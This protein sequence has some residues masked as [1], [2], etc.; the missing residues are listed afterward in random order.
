MW[1]HPVR[2]EVASHSCKPEHVQ[3]RY[4][5]LNMT[6]IELAQSKLSEQIL[7]SQTQTDFMKPSQIT[8]MSQISVGLDVQG[9]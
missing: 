9:H 5:S 1:G 6:G 3:G 7:R 4:F 2:K 8:D